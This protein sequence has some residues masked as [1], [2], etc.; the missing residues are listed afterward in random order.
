M[1][2]IKSIDK[3]IYEPDSDSLSILYFG[4]RKYE[5][6]INSKIHNFSIDFTLKIERLSGQLL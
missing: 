5:C 6:Q 3:D 1:N 4:S 2:N